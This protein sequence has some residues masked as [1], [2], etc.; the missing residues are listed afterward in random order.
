MYADGASEEATWLALHSPGGAIQRALS[1]DSVVSETSVTDFDN[2]DD[3]VNK[4]GQLE[5]S[6]Q[7]LRYVSEPPGGALCF[8][9]TA[10][11]KI[12]LCL[13]LIYVC[14]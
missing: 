13:L 7:Y 5:F 2:V 3:V 6:L 11:Y 14:E 1:C 10:P 9:I 12:L 8:L 4:I